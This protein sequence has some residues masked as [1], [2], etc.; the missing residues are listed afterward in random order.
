MFYS[1]RNELTIHSVYFA[2][3]PKTIVINYFIDSALIFFSS[4]TAGDLLANILQGPVE[5]AIGLVIGLGWGFIA[6]CIPHR[7]EVI[8]TFTN[9]LFFRRS[10]IL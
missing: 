7:S 3:A 10:E 8:F 4:F 9:F 6:A 2:N 5:I 1:R